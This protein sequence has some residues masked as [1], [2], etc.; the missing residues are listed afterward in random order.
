M[1]VIFVRSGGILLI[2]EGNAGA[3]F[4]VFR[5]LFWSIMMMADRMI[6]VMAGIRIRRNSIT[7]NVWVISDKY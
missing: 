1:G 2:L 7:G 4:R 5:L 3:S 6:M